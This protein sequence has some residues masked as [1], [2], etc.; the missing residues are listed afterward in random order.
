MADGFLIVMN[1]HVP[2]PLAERASLFNCSNVK[3]TEIADYIGI[4]VILIHFLIHGC[5]FSNSAVTDKGPEG[6]GSR[7]VCCSVMILNIKI[8]M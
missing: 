2:H 5:H 7:S 6:C 8:L 1:C 3:F 4:V